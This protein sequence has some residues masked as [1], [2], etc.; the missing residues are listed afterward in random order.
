MT[1]VCSLT[2]RAVS[3]YVLPV[4]GD[5]PIL[6]GMSFLEEVGAIMDL[7]RGMIVFAH[8]ADGKPRRVERNAK[9]HIMI[10]LTRTPTEESR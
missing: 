1:L 4:V 7:A 9:G 3:M 10:D 2:S 8:V 6:V 5:V